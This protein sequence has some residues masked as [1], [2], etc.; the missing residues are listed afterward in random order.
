MEVRRLFRLGAVFAGAFLAGAFREF[1]EDTLPSLD[2]GLRLAKSRLR[3][4][5]GDFFSSSSFTPLLL[6]RRSRKFV[7][8]RPSASAVV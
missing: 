7:E 8:T 4:A 5:T 6:E 1:R 2:E 3:L